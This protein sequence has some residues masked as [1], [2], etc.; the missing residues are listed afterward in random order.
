[1]NALPPLFS[2]HRSLVLGG[3]HYCLDLLVIRGV[4]TTLVDASLMDSTM[5]REYKKGITH[6]KGQGVT[7][8]LVVVTL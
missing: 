3:V 6:G 5:I 8:L 7:V 1:M 2:P 4:V